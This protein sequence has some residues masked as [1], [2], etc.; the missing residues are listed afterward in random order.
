MGLADYLTNVQNAQNQMDLEQGWAQAEDALGIKPETPPATDVAAPASTPTETPTDGQDG[1]AQTPVDGSGNALRDWVTSKAGTGASQIKI[2]MSVIQKASSLVGHDMQLTPEQLDKK[3]TL[4][5]GAGDFVPVAETVLAGGDVKAMWERQDKGEKVPTWEKVL[6]YASIPLSLIG[7]AAVGRGVSGLVKGAKEVKAASEAVNVV[8]DTEKVAQLAEEAVKVADPHKLEAIDHIVKMEDDMLASGKVPTGEEKMARFMLDDKDP[9]LVSKIDELKS[10]GQ[11]FKSEEEATAAARDA[12]KQDMGTGKFSPDLEEVTKVKAEVAAKNFGASA[13]PTSQPVKMVDVS[14]DT[15]EG[16]MDNIREYDKWTKSDPLAKVV[17]SGEIPH[18]NLDNFGSTDDIKAALEFVA[19]KVQIPSGVEGWE[20]TQKAGLAELLGQPLDKM[21]YV[22]KNQYT[23]ARHVFA[24][25]ALLENATK[26]V[27]DFAKAY[28]PMK[29]TVEERAKAMRMVQQLSDI[30]AYHTGIRAEAGRAL[31]ASKIMA[32]E[33]KNLLKTLDEMIN[34]EHGGAKTVDD[35]MK[36]MGNADNAAQA[37]QIARNAAT[38]NK[39]WDSAV[40][41]WMGSV[42]S[43]TSTAAVNMVGNMF[44]LIKEVPE[45]TIAGGIGKLRQ[46]VTGAKTG[47]DAVDPKEGLHLLVG[48]MEGL[49]EAIKTFGK[50]FVEGR[51]VWSDAMKTELAADAMSSAKEPILTRRA[52][53]AENFGL[54]SVM[55]KNMFKSAADFRQGLVKAGSDPRT[56]AGSVVDLFGSVVRTPMGVLTSTD[57]FFKVLAYRMQINALAYREAMKTGATDSKQ[58]AETFLNFK[59]NPPQELKLAAVNYADYVT[60]QAPLEETGKMIQ[61]LT[62]KGYTPADIPVFKF[63]I[64]FQKTVTNIFKQGVLEHSP[65][66]FMSKGVWGELKAGG[67]RSDAMASKLMAGS[68]LMMWATWE[69]SKGNVSGPKPKDPAMAQA[70]EREGVQ[71]YS[72]KVQDGYDASGQPKY[73]WVS[74]NRIEPAAFPIAMGATIGAYMNA[75]D[76]DNPLHEQDLEHM[77]NGA[78]GALTN[79]IDDKTYLVGMADLIDALRGDKSI[80]DWA[81]RYASSWVPA[82]ANDFVRAKSDNI[83]DVNEFADKSLARLP[84]FSDNVPDALNIWGEPRKRERGLFLGFADPIKVSDDKRGSPIDRE[85]Y[86]LGVEGVKEGDNAKPI[87]FPEVLLRQPDRV[88]KGHELS[89]EMYNQYMKTVGPVAKEKLNEL[90]TSQHYKSL[91]PKAKATAIRTLYNGV[92]EAMTNKFIQDT[93]EL[94]DHVQGINQL[95]KEL[96]QMR[97]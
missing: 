85:V 84:V 93:P 31:N 20:Q 92:T 46:Y 29:A 41:L 95:K 68:S 76:H 61:A 88:I 32:L 27:S 12:L 7:L 28:D 15:A 16:V 70:W 72:V 3:I 51:P 90:V 2:P 69:A 81:G 94:M 59:K 56:L 14:Q 40:E 26:Q 43:S 80:Y 71:P 54:P 75:M 36:A 77:I 11:T 23:S 50:S 89:S 4:D 82:A 49:P 78:V 86:R 18:I 65:F 21:D 30:Y 13:S 22:F 67:A 35:I 52:I 87:V 53:S 62:N 37:V 83:K 96:M 55:D 73:K 91:S 64:P 47:V 57:E 33:N 58:L 5:I 25:K 42:L 79:Y 9:A 63:I 6:T 60:F 39:W 45:R 17:L 24:A 74:F 48:M 34:V 10:S 44:N 8:K 19:E 38:K 1:S 66:G 97:E